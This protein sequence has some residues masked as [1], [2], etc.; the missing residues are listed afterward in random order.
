MS[1]CILVLLVAFIVPVPA[2]SSECPAVRLNGSGLWY[3]VSLRND[4]GGTLRGIFPDLAE[5]VFQNLGVALDTGSDLPWKRLLTLL[6]NGQIDVLAGAYL[7][8]EREE[9]FGV[10]LPVMREDVAVFIR[11]SL[12]SRPQSLEDLVGLQGVAPFGA[13][14]G[15]EFEAF[16]ASKLMIDRQPFDE[17]DTLMWLLIENKADYLVMARQDGES[18]IE[19]TSAHGK[20]E[21]LPWRAAVNTLHFMF[22][23]QTPCIALLEPFNE[24]L[25]RQ[26]NAG[27]LEEL[28]EDYARAA[29][30]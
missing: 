1:S 15:E 16:A 30:R 7:T 26:L 25:Q 3:P 4:E 22:S 8:G 14:F 29:G 24:G 11:S 27:R 10:S 13:S 2:A 5:E 21:M 12:P 28:V 19:D 9:K 20:V 17:L 6:E 18:M 23:R